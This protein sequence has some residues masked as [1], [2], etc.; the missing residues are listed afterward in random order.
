MAKIEWN[1]KLSVGVDI[2]D[3]QHKEW[4]NRY[5]KTEAAIIA[6]RGEEQVP[7]ELSFLIDYTESHFDTEEKLMDAHSYP[8]R[9]EHKAFH[10]SLKKTLNSL[11]EEFEEEGST[12]LLAESVDTFL[13]NWL[14]KH[15]QE[16]D[17]KLGI[18][19][20]DKNL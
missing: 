20:K 7:N 15:I 11:V 13:G 6:Q 3:G 19:L 1:D 14:I 17:K 9:E 10:A 2:I 4:I 12:T 5:N 8:E 16:V 18:F